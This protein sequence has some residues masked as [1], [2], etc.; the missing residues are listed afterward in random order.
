MNSL[1]NSLN[2]WLW[3]AP[4]SRSEVSLALLACTQTVL[5]H[6]CGIDQLS[7]RDCRTIESL[8]LLGL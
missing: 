1:S 5:E 8:S 4:K 7:A 6:S 2:T 3:L